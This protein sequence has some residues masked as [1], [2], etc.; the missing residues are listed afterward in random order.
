MD[1]LS[2]I[3]PTYNFTLWTVQR[4]SF[5]TAVTKTMLK[6]SFP[7]CTDRPLLSNSR[8]R[9]SYYILT[10]VYTCLPSDRCVAPDVYV[11]VCMHL[12]DKVFCPHVVAVRNCPG[13]ATYLHRAWLA[14]CVTRADTQYPMMYIWSKLNSR[15]V[16]STLKTSFSLP[17]PD[18]LCCRTVQFHA[19]KQYF[20]AFCIIPLSDCS[21]LLSDSEV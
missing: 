10:A 8:C 4:T 1:I 2:I 14:I 11:A 21:C 17:P 7:F 15:Y 13:V 3:L 16:I 9:Q 5:L 12:T 20:A 19:F 6:T 18:C